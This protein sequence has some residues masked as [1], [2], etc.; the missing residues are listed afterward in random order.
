MTKHKRH[1]LESIV[2]VGTGCILA[3]SVSVIYF[4]FIPSPDPFDTLILTGML[5]IASVIRGYI[6]RVYFHGLWRQRKITKRRSK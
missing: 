3:F 5:T 1:M 6:W 2:N 4:H